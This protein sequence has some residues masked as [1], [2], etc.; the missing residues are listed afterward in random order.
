MT[1]G[2]RNMYGF[3]VFKVEV[4][5]KID[6]NLRGISSFKRWRNAG[7]IGAARFRHCHQFITSWSLT[8]VLAMSP[9]ASCRLPAKGSSNPGAIACGASCWEK[10]QPQ[11]FSVGILDNLPIDASVFLT[12]CGAHVNLLPC[13]WRVSSSAL[14]LT[15]GAKHTSSK[16]VQVFRLQLLNVHMATVYILTCVMNLML[17]GDLLHQRCQWTHMQE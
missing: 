17:M 6:T 7:H 11:T 2:E 16:F 8:F 15:T 3:R 4:W 1:G 12:Q 9:K 10:S 13:M 5:F 14:L